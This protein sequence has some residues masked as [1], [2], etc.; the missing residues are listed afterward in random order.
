MLVLKARPLT[1]YLRPTVSL[2]KIPTALNAVSVKNII[3]GEELNPILKLR[4]IE[5]EGR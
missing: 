5:E 3:V 2:S 1:S 4:D